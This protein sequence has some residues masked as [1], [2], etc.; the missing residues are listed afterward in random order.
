[1]AK[2]VLHLLTG[3]TA[4][5]KSALALR[6]AEEFGAE[7]ICA[8]STTVY[9][10]MDVGTAKPTAEERAR[11]PHHLLDVA[12]VSEVFDVSEF[13]RQAEKAQV[14]GQSSPRTS[15]RVRDPR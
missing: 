14:S 12:D 8:D 1:M 10:G 4:C 11:V 9:R 2:P 15:R 7:I 6:W 3:P 5:G 13:A